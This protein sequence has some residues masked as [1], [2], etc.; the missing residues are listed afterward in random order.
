MIAPISRIRRVRAVKASEPGISLLDCMTDPDLFGPWFRKDWQS[1]SA[2]AVFISALF[3]LPMDKQM[4][5][6]FRKHTGRTNPPRSIGKAAWLVCGRRSGKSFILAL[7]GVYLACFRNY[8]QHLAPGERATVMIIAA[9]RKQSRVILRYITA[10]LQVPLLAK[11]VQRTWAEGFDL[12]GGVSIEV[13]T[14]SFRSVRGYSI[15]VALADECCF[16]SSDDSAEPDYE[17]INALRPGMANIPTSMLLCASSP[18]AKRGVMWDAYQK[19]WGKDDAELC[20]QAA[21]REMNA[22]IPQN[23]IDDEYTRDPISAASE[24]GGEWRSDISAFVSR[25]VIEACT[26]TGVF[27]RSPVSGIKYK[28]FTDPSGG[29]S[30]AFTLCI[31]HRDDGKAVIDCVREVRPKFSPDDVCAEFSLV[32]KSYGLTSV[33]GDRY[34]ALWPVE[35]FKA[36]GVTYEQS[37]RPKSELYQSLL[38]TLNS[39]QISLLDNSRIN[40]QL[41]SLERRTSKGGAEKIDHPPGPNS[42]DDLANVIAGAVSCLGQKKYAYDS[43]LYF[44]SGDMTQEES[45][46]AFQ[47]ERLANHMHTPFWG[48]RGRRY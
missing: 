13:A 31:A 12:S 42:H 20:W 21:T 11:K 47:F 34:A 22:G 6:I 27:E 2:W 38:P 41:V 19:N 46:R 32:L 14:S 35:R 29:S 48:G 25:E 24:F 3:C 17:V 10:L 9:D 33:V 45:S 5:A 26:E 7:I 43:D 16:W 23:F 28:A 15:C 1:W 4:L 8:A 44:V 36:H 39:K 40:A 30:D 18:Y 37:A